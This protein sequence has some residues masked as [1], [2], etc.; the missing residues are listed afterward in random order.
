MDKI[1]LSQAIERLVA[2]KLADQLVLNFAKLRQNVHTGL[3]ERAL[4]GKFVET[5]V[6]CMMQISGEYTPKITGIDRYLNDVVVHKKAV[7]EAQGLRK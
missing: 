5:L 6:N 1:K 4:A 2:P 7:P 3:L